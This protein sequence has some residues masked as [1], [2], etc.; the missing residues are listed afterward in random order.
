MGEMQKRCKEFMSK[1]ANCGENKE[2]NEEIK[3][4]C[5]EKMQKAAEFFAKM[6]CANQEPRFPEN[7]RD[8]AR[9]AQESQDKVAQKKEEVKKKQEEVR[10]AK[11]KVEALKKEMKACKKEM[12]KEKKASKK[13]MKEAKK[14]L[15]KFDAQVVAHLDTDEKSVQKP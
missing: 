13:A 7:R 14:S 4:H 2:C 15:K 10:E 5:Q 11:A 1:M 3:K 6:R 8:P 12:K 9:S